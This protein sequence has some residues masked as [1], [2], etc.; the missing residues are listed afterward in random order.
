MLGGLGL[1]LPGLLRISA[2]TDALA[3][4]GLVII[5]IGATVISFQ[6]GPAV[7]CANALVVGILLVFVRI[8]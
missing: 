1:V 3:A 2:W 7:G 5:M 8:R 4:S 6:I